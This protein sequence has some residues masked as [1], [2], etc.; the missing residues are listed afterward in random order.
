M[1]VDAGTLTL[2]ALLLPAAAFLILA[3]VAPL[4]RDGR[5]AAYLSV[6]FAAAALGAAI[7][8]WRAHVGGAVTRL[9]WEWLPAKDMTLATVGILADADSTVMLTLVALVAFLVQL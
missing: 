8:S 3:I 4:R 6:L 9:V 7:L 5:P 1:T 2:V